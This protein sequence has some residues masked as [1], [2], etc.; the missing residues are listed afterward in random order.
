MAPGNR[1]SNGVHQDAA[2]VLVVT[3]L[4]ITDVCGLAA[5]VLLI[6]VL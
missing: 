1:R 5:A 6:G 4:Q 2:V 3:V